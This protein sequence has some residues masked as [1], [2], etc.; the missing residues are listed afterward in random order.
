MIQRGNS[1]NKIR[2]YLF[3]KGIKDEFIKETVNKINNQNS[4]QDFFQQL[5]YVKK[6]NR[7]C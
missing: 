4:E 7:T 5:N 3:A 1:I 2:N 6:E